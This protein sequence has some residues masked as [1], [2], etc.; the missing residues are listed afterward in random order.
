MDEPRFY[1]FPTYGHAGPKIGQD[2]GGRE[3]TPATRTFERDDE[4]LARAMA[5]LEARLPG[6]AGEPFLHQDLPVHDD[7]GPG[8]RRRRR[9]RPPGRARLPGCGTRLQV[10][11]A[12]SGRILAELA[13]DGSTPSAPELEAFRIDRPD[14]ARGQPRRTVRWS[15]P[16]TCPAARTVRAR[17]CALRGPVPPFAHPPP[18]S[19]RPAVSGGASGR[20]TD[21]RGGD[22]DAP[23]SRAR[24]AVDRRA[25]ASRI[26]LLP[27]ASRPSPPTA[28]SCHP[29]CRDDQELTLATRGNSTWWWTTRRSSSPTTCCVNF[30][31]NAKP[32]PGLRRPWERS[33]TDKVTFHIRDGMKWSDGEP[34][35]SADVCFSWGLAMDAIDDRCYIGAGYLDPDLKNAGVTKVECPDDEHLRRLHDGPVT[36][37]SSRPMCRSCR[38]TSGG[39]YTC[40]KIAEQ[41]FDA[42]LVGTGPYTAGRVEDRPVR[43]LRPQPQLLGQPGPR[44]RGRPPVLPRR[45]RHDGPGPQVG[46]PRL[47]PQR[48]P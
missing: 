13:V 9:A 45:H 40:E 21:S 8:L 36:T 35:T 41:K 10:R 5:F 14:P 29:A 33:R 44:G 42:P 48:E 38:S 12:C 1:G 31:K 26:A 27:A 34:A 22:P 30:D 16:L 15:E 46:R 32:G 47:R 39:E 11:V 20:P 28:M 19:A 4:A 6:M 43:P 3:V 18:G 23:A 25:A 2:V 17:S 7:P 37:A 24:E